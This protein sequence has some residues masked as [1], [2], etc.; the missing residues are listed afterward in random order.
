MALRLAHARIFQARLGVAPVI[1]ADDVLGELDPHRQAGFWR[2]CPEEFQII[3]SG[4]VLPSDAARWRVYQVD[5]GAFQ[6]LPPQGS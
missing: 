1:L 3:A 6:A 5:G 2:A 4:T